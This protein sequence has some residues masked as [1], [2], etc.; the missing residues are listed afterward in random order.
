VTLAIF[1]ALQIA[2]PLWIRPNLFPASHRTLAITAQT[3]AAVYQTNSPH[4]FTYTLAAEGLPGQPDAWIQS[5]AATNAEGH[6]VSNILPA[7][8]SPQSSSASFAKCLTDHGIRLGVSYQPA[9]RYWPLQ[10]AETGIYL[11]LSLLLIGYCFR[12][13]RHLA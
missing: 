4:T 5:S 2:M 8:C 3:P 10:A 11:I 13:I 1:A 9:S 12:R 6:P 7:D